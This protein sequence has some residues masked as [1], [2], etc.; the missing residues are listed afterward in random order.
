M[1]TSTWTSRCQPCTHNQWTVVNL[2]GCCRCTSTSCLKVGWRSFLKP[3]SPH[4]CQEKSLCCRPPR[5]ASIPTPVPGGTTIRNSNYPCD[6]SSCTPSR[7]MVSGVPPPAL[8]PSW[9]VC[10]AFPR[11]TMPPVSSVSCPS[12]G[13]IR[14]RRAIS[15]GPRFGIVLHRS[16]VLAVATLRIMPCCCARCS[17]GSTWKRM[18]WLGPP[19]MVLMGGSWR[20][21]SNHKSSPTT[22]R[23]W[24][25]S[26]TSTRVWRA[27][28]LNSPTPESIRC[29][30]KWVAS[31]TIS[32]STPT[33]NRPI[34]C[35][36]LTS[37]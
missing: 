17:W 16:W 32:T 23:E 26:T 2:W 22:T 19:Q 35:P 5:T 7:R 13:S 12:S 4:N 9:S 24:N 31:S 37:I 33:F 29:T 10:V 11:P 3:C 20:G 6:Q 36:Q 21:T 8:S 27:T 18:S 28:S 1:A 15:R 14:D 25:T 30:K 34:R